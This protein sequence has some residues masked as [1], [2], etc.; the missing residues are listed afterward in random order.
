MNVLISY[1]FTIL[2]DITFG[3]LLL[4]RRRSVKYTSFLL[5]INYIL[6]L[7]ACVIYKTFLIGTNLDIYASTILGFIFVIYFILAFKESLLK[8]IFTMFTIRLFSVIILIIS[9]YVISLFS[10]EDFNMYQLLTIILRNVIQLMFIPIVYLKFKGTYKE[11]L[12]S[13][14]NKVINIIT[15]YSII[16]FLFLNNYYK[17]DLYNN[18]YSNGILNSLVFIFIIILSYIIVFMA[19]YYV[20]KNIELEYKFNI[21]GT[22]IELQKQNY[23]TLSKS[24]ESY[25]AFKHDIR[26]HLLAIKSLMDTKNY[27]AVSEYLKKFSETEIGQNIDILCQNFTVDSILKYYMNIAVKNNIDFKVNANIPQDINID[28][29]ELSVVI[30][31]CVENAIEA[32]NN[33]TYQGKKYIDIKAQIKGSQLVIKIINSFNGQ[34]IEEGNIIKTSKSGEEHGIGLSNVRNIV[35]KY[36]GYFNVKHDDKEF[37][38]H[39][40]MNIN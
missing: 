18:S 14:P 10:I 19:I 30:G 40:V 29:I 36:K 31:N 1:T 7:F 32:C 17:F 20:N 23:K 37:E 38:V 22:Q 5:L 33:I 13:I 3:N 16:I 4:T 6:F 35:Q 15:V 26:H 2:I 27:I 9:T 39:I 28:N 25:Y 34:V 12:K 8:K 11:M 21:I 24:L